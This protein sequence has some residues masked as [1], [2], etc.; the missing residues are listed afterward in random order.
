[1]PEG[2]IE[3]IVECKEE[4]AQNLIPCDMGLIENI[5][6]CKDYVAVISQKPQAD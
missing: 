6:E 1:M 2:L 4:W 3:N 5:V